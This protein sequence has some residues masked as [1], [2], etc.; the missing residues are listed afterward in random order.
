MEDFEIGDTVTTVKKGKKHEHYPEKGRIFKVFDVVPTPKGVILV[1][2]MG[3][4]HGGISAIRCRIVHRE[5][6]ESQIRPAHYGGADN[7]FEAIKVIEGL[8]LDFIEGNI[9]KYLFRYKKKNGLMDLK[10]SQWYLDRLIKNLENN[11]Q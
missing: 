3:E 7:P 11:E 5:E 1:T 2:D 9:V 6:K 8:K 10:K 4:E